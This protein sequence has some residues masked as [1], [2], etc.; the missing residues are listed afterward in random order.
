[1][2]IRVLLWGGT[3]LLADQLDNAGDRPP[4]RRN[5]ITSVFQPL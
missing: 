4:K 3:G 1:M 5:G 2:H